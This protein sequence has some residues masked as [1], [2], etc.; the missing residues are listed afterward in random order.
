MAL[1]VV[2]QVDLRAIAAHSEGIAKLPYIVDRSWALKI[3]NH[4]RKAT[5]ILQVS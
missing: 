3:G 4:G 1:V 5:C 2:K